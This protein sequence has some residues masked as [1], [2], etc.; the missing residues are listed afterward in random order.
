MRDLS[1]MRLGLGVRQLTVSFLWPRLSCTTACQHVLVW[2]TC[3]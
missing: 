2:A 3:W 1:R